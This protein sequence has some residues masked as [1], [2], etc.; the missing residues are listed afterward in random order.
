VTGAGTPPPPPGRRRRWLGL[1]LVLS[2]AVNLFLVGILAG[3]W[4]ARGPAAGFDP[5]AGPA[6]IPHMIRA[7]PPTARDAA[8]ERFAERRRALRGQMTAL[9]RARQSVYEALTAEA[10][11]RAALEAAL[12]DL[13]EQVAALQAGLHEAI[14]AVA[15][16]LEAEDRR[17]MAETLRGLA[18]HRGR[19][20]GPGRGRG[21]G[22]GRA[23]PP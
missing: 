10:F 21:F 13:R 8:L 15:E 9:R 14:V 5:A 12:G 4:L 16:R 1:A 7:L 11:D 19:G 23:E 20:M 18:R 3:G 17:E 2:L 22:E 6:S